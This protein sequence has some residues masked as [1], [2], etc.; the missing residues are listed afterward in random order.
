[1]THR[2]AYSITILSELIEI[3][4][5]ILIQMIHMSVQQEQRT[6]DQFRIYNYF[7]FKLF[8]CIINLELKTFYL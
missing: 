8:H 3:S 4:Y 5:I 6:Q 1:M 7:L 2:K